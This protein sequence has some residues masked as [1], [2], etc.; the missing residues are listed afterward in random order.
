MS[1]FLYSFNKPS[2][3]L[4]DSGCL[5]EITGLTNYKTFYGKD[6]KIKQVFLPITTNKLL[7]GAIYGTP[8]I[9]IKKLNREMAKCS[10]DFFIY[11]EFSEGMAKLTSLI[12]TESG[13]LNQVDLEQIISE[14]LQSY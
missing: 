10:Q 12:G 14:A 8:K 2:V 9:N 13:I 1:W 5:F 7:I 3:I 4:G 6:E 11:S